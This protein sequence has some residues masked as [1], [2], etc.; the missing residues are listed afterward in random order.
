MSRRFCGIQ[1]LVRLCLRR[2]LVSRGTG[3]APGQALEQEPG[4]V[5]EQLPEQVPVMILYW[6]AFAGADGQMHFR[7]DP[8]NWDRLLLTKVG[9]VGQTAA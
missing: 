2:Y 4:Q 9:V 3:P 7:G 1:R 5:P 6:T 8:Y